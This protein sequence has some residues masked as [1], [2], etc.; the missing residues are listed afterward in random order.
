M[1]FIPQT[2]G[3]ESAAS[4]I[5]TIPVGLANVKPSVDGLWKTGEW[6]D[7]VE[8]NVSYVSSNGNYVPSQISQAFVRLK[9]DGTNLYGI[10]DVPTDTGPAINKDASVIVSFNGPWTGTD[11]TVLAASDQNGNITLTSPTYTASIYIAQNVGVSPHSDVNHRVWEFELPIKYLI[12]QPTKEPPKIGF[13]LGVTDWHKNSHWLLP[14]NEQLN[15]PFAQLQFGNTVLPEN[16]SL[17]LPLMFL[18]TCLLAYWKRRAQG[19]M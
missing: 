9:H 15:G 18:M 12:Q 2:L 16:V 19:K 7:A 5:T 6:D 10:V 17:L 8:S 3:L 1:T 14:P 4:Q 11:D 13:Q